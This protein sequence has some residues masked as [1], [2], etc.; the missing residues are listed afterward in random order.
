MT[1]S[2]Y[3]KQNKND[4][5]YVR[6]YRPTCEKSLSSDCPIGSSGQS[7]DET[8]FQP[9]HGTVDGLL[10][11]ISC[12]EQRKAFRCAGLLFR[13]HL[14]GESLCLMTFLQPR[15]EIRGRGK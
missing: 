7:S 10:D 5:L 14:S 4:L 12:V 13:V 15:A 8:G 2:G 3:I 11:V 6:I 9:E 1:T